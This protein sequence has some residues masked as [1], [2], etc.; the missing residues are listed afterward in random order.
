MCGVRTETLNN[1]VDP[2]VVQRGVALATQNAARIES[3]EAARGEG[4]KVSGYCTGS[5]GDEYFVTVDY[6]LGTDGVVT[7]FN[8]W[9]ACPYGERCKHA[10]AL[11]L[12]H[13]LDY[14][15]IGKREPLGAFGE[16]VDHLVECTDSFRETREVL[17]EVLGWERRR[18]P[19]RREPTW[20]ELLEEYLPVESAESSAATPVAVVFETD[21]DVVGDHAVLRNL[22]VTGGR[23]RK[24]GR[25][26]VSSDMTLTKLQNGTGHPVAERDRDR[27]IEI[28][29]EAGSYDIHSQ[30]QS[31]RSLR[32]PKFF[33]LLDEAQE[34]GIELTTADGGSSSSMKSRS[35]Q[36]CT[37]PRMMRGCAWTPRS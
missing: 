37:S 5:R 36:P 29:S 2:R 15:E 33:A 4:A 7:A 26:W 21:F 24:N 35:P 17:S 1:F 3:V 20:Q 13:H 12:K 32:S 10:V 31:L 28:L 25:G 22:S 14:R 11:A 19:V 8:S 27:L 30:P 9:C 16:F 18:R 6:T 23:P 34:H